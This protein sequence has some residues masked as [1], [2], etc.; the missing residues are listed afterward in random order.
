MRYLCEDKIEDVEVGDRPNYGL[1]S[2]GYTIQS[3]APTEY[4]IR[5]KGEKRLRRV[6]VWCFSNCATYFVR[7]NGSPLA[8]SFMEQIKEMADEKAHVRNSVGIR[9]HTYLD[10]RA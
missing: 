7:I 8:I 3:G 6:F 9:S 4:R 2:E 5:L 10:Q 1:T